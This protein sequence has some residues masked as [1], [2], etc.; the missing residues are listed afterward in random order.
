M[1]KKKAA[2]VKRKRKA[3]AALPPCEWPEKVAIVAMG[4]SNGAWLVISGAHGG[5]R[6]LYDEVWTINATGGLIEHHRCFMMDDVK[7]ILGAQAALTGRDEKKVAQ[8]IFKWLPYHPGPIYTSTTY[9]EWPALV[10]YPI[11]DVLDAVRVPYLTNTVAYA[12]AFAVMLHKKDP[13]ACKEVWL[14]GCDFNYRGADMHAEAG[15]GSAEF[16]VGIAAEIGMDIILPDSTTFL[17]G[18]V[19]MHKKLYGYHGPLNITQ[20]EDGRWKVKREPPQEA[21]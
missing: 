6:S 5:W 10:E 11:E 2:P 15:R 19:P 21:A 13:R 9:P 16:V 14:F 4:A 12:L 8:G 17:D 20:D 3:G 1:A 18:D 7:H